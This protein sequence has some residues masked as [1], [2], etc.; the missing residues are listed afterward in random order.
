[1]IEIEYARLPGQALPSV[2]V[3]VKLKMPAVVGDPV[4]APVAVLSD[5]P[6]R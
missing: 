5:R 1:M 2:A 4:M 3:M 6:G